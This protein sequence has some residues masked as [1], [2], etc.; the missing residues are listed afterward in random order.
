MKNILRFISYHNAIPIGLGVIFLGSGAALAA[1]PDVRDTFISSETTIRSVDNSYLLSAD[2]DAFSPGL[3][4]TDVTE[5]TSF[6]YVSYSYT[7]VGIDD[8][9]WKPLAR[10]KTLSVSKVSLQGRDLGLFV[11]QELG[12]V[13]D[14][15]VRYAKEAQGIEREKGRSVK[16][17]TVAYAGLI[18]QFLEPN[19]MVFEGYT[20]VIPE[21]PLVVG[22]SST[23]SAATA[24]TVIA[25]VG[26]PSVSLGVADREEI[27]RIVAETVQSI[28]ASQPQPAAVIESQNETA[29]EEESVGTE[30]PAPS[31]TVAP[32]ITVL[33]NNPADIAVG[34]GYS[35]LGATV[36][37]NVN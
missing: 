9:V 16:I 3:R 7:E 2:F 5:D 26:L 6:Y 31:D 20:P 8:Y 33:G 37:D 10:V 12:E 1:S 19:E 36:T 24:D 23:T 21:V 15:T 22:E 29:T 27:R 30:Q 28:L 25:D 4:I 11:A 34:A 13:T 35:D 14:M 18:G 17:A 32:V